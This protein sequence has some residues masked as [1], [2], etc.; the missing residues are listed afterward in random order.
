METGQGGQTTPHYLQELIKTFRFSKMSPG[1]LLLPSLFAFLSLVL[2]TIGFSQLLKLGEEAVTGGISPLESLY[3]VQPILWG[4]VALLGFTIAS[5]IAVYNLLK[6]LKDHFYQSGVTVYYFTGG[7]S[8]EGAMQYLRSILVRSTLPSPVTG[9]LLMFLTS[10]VA[11]PVILCFAEKAVREHAIVEEEA[12]FRTKFTSEYKWFNMLIDFAL[13]PLTLG[14]YL[15]YM[16]RRVAKVFNAHVNAIHSSHP[17]PPTL[18]PHGTTVQELRPTSSLLIGLLL[19]SIGLNIVTSYIGLFTASYVAYSCGILLS[20]LVLARRTKGTSASSVLVVLI[21]LYLLVFGGLLAGM[22]GYETY[23][24]LT[25]TIRRQT[26]VA[27]SMKMLDLATYIF[28]NNLV[29]SLPSIVPYVGGVLVAQGVYNAGLVVGTIAGSGL[30]SPGDVVLVLVYPHS[31]LELSAYAILLT[32]SSFLGEWRRYTV[33]AATGILLLFTAALVE[34]L[35]IKYLQGSS[36]LEG[37]AP[38]QGS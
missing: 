31:I 15:A 7:P 20:A 30:R 36:L 6:N 2:F 8:F 1:L 33:L 38:L 28:V 34:A 25:D 16:G 27:S 12:L 17:N 14:L 23:R 32:S 24:V 18:P 13:V 19:L 22:T 11:Y 29:I 4:V 26:N 21:L 9:I 3:V 37:L 5:M 10:G 35:T